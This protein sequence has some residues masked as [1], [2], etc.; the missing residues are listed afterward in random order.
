MPQCQAVFVRMLG[1][2]YGRWTLKPMP[3]RNTSEQFEG[4]PARMRVL[5]EI[6][7][8]PLVFSGRPIIFSLHTSEHCLTQRHMLLKKKNEM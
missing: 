7:Q 8:I 5:V 2:N 1:K 4:P 6:E 3:R